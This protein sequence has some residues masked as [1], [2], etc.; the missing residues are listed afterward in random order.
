MATYV[1]GDIQGCFDT[2]QELLSAIDYREGVDALVLLGDL[3][4]RGPASLEVARW[5]LEQGEAVKTVLGN[6]DVH[7]L[8][9][10]CGAQ[11][12][13]PGDTL[14]PLLRWSRRE[15]F[16]QWLL[17]QSFYLRRNEW[18]FVHAGLLPGWSLAEAQSFSDE[19]MALLRGE[20]AASVLSFYRGDP[21][22]HFEEAKTDHQRHQFLL[23][24]FTRMRLCTVEGRLNLGFF[25][26]L[27]ELPEGFLPWFRHWK[28]Q[29][30]ERIV[31]GHWAALGVH[32]EG[33]CLGLDSGCVWGRQLSALCLESGAVT[34]VATRP[35]DVALGG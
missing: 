24:V 25:G 4:N 18:S 20:D 28:G 3:V 17:G 33:S 5:A 29:A 21:V 13:G 16:R 10:L 31:F 11:E 7:F 22:F 27:K 34:Q 12:P 2:F 32:Q 23:N 19:L 26:G 35:G 1:V 30:S 14:G 8:A 15:E 6:H 9:L